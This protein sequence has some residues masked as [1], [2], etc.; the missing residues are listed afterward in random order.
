[1]SSLH[2]IKEEFV[3]ENDDDDDFDEEDEVDLTQLVVLRARK[4]SVRFLKGFG[5]G[6]GVYTGIKI[7]TS[8]MR[9]PFRESLPKI[10]AEILAK[11]SFKFA[12]FLGLFPSIYDLIVELLEHYRGRRDDFNSAIAG[13]VA[14]LSMVVEDRTRRRI[15]CLFAIARAVGAMVTTL[16]KRG[17]IPAVPYS[18]TALFCSCTSFLVYCTALKPQYL[19]TGYYR[20]VLKWSRDYTDKK[21]N[22]L[23][24]EPGTKFLTCAEAGLHEQSCTYHAFKDFLQSLPPFAKLYL[25][26]H[27]APIIFFR[28]KQFLKRPKRSLTSLLKNIVFSTA[29]LATMVM[30]AKYGI[31]LLRNFQFRE[32]PLSPWIPAMAGFVAGLGVLFERENRRR[33][34]SLFLIPHTLYAVYLWAK[35]YGIIRHIPHSSLFMYAI[36]MVPIMH[37]YEREP[38]SLNLL[39]HSALKFFVGKRQSTIERKKRRTVSEMSM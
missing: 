2:P 35:E 11:D 24:R 28:Y 13:G 17:L 21:L 16:V 33:E 32:P 15:Y 39:L 1:M 4:F 6:L 30:L 10:R 18:E 23:F 22:V 25:P 38:E 20:S 26:I 37:A 29:F 12:A 5:S 34:L 31:C 14:G 36:A 8:L 7:V 19:F 9:N 3:L 27:M